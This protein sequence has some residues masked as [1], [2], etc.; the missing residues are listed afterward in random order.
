LGLDNNI[1]S[2]IAT[3]DTPTESDALDRLLKAKD[4]GKVD[5]V[6][7]ELTLQEIKRDQ[8]PMRPRVERIFRL[9]EKVPIVRWDQLVGMHS[10]GDAR[11]WITSPLIDNDPDYRALLELGVKTVDAQH[12]FVAARHAC[13]A[14]LTCDG[15]VLH[16]PCAR[17]IEKRFG[18]VVQR[19]SG[20]VASQGW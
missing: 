4:E 5:L 19:P 2:A 12:V 17:A 6:T 16:P 14:F 7:S 15:G 20:F 13:D 3:D 9:L 11:T 8:G 1:V 18:L 10:Y